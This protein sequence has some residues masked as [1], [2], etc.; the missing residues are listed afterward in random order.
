MIELFMSC[1]LGC[2]TH[3]FSNDRQWLQEDVDALRSAQPRCITHYP[4]SPC[5]VKF[6]KKE[7]LI[8]WATCGKDNEK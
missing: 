3:V 6:A 7:P 8:Y 5:L 2:C 4:G 1:I